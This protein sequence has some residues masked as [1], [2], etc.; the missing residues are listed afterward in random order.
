MTATDAGA[1]K[2]RTAATA[3]IRSR[4]SKRAAGLRA[5]RRGQLDAELA[6]LPARTSTG[7]PLSRK[8]SIIAWFSGSTSA[9]NV[10]IPCGG[11]LLGRLR[12]AGSCRPRVPASRRRPRRR[13]PRA[14]P[15]A[16]EQRVTDDVAGLAGD[17]DEAADP[18][19]RS[20][21]ARAAACMSVPAEKKR[22]Q[23]DRATGSEQRCRAAARPRAGRAAPAASSRRAGR[24]SN[25]SRGALRSTDAT[26]AGTAARATSS[27]EMTTRQ[28]SPSPRRRGA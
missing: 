16:R 19:S 25:A 10:S 7:K 15:V 27:D 22:N 3:A 20:P 2:W 26:S 24:T 18:W 5:D 14:A 23:R 28:G 11:R 9:V 13:P 8:T 12:R 4:S 1:R 17:R 21:P 6:R